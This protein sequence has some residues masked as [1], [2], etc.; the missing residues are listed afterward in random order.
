MPDLTC[1]QC[2]AVYYSGSGRTDRCPRCRQQPAVYQPPPQQQQ[3]QQLAGTSSRGRD[4]NCLRCGRAY[5]T[6]SGRTRLCMTCRQSE[7]SAPVAGSPKAAAGPSSRAPQPDSWPPF[8]PWASQPAQ[9]LP[10]AGP[11]SSA[12]DTLAAPSLKQPPPGG[13]AQ[14]PPPPSSLPPSQ[15]TR[16]GGR[17]RPPPLAVASGSPARGQSGASPAFPPAPSASESGASTPRLPGSYK[18]PAPPGVLASVR[19]A[20]RRA[21]QRVSI[22][23]GSPKGSSRPPRFASS[24]GGSCKSPTGA[25]RHGSPSAAARAPMQSYTKHPPGSGSPRAAAGSPGPAS[26][27]A[28][29]AAWG[30]AKRTHS[31]A[32]CG[33]SPKAASSPRR[34]TY[35]SAPCGGSPKASVRR[36][37]SFA[38]HKRPASVGGPAPSGA[39]RPPSLGAIPR[40]GSPGVS[41]YPR[42][43]SGSLNVSPVSGSPKSLPHRFPFGEPPPSGSPKAASSRRPSGGSPLAG[44]PK[45]A[46]PR[47]ASGTSPLGGSPKAA[48]RR[49]TFPQTGEQRSAVAPGPPQAS[50]KSASL[51][52][53]GPVQGSPKA[54][55]LRRERRATLEGPPARRSSREEHH[56]RPAEVRPRGD[57][58]FEVRWPEAVQRPLRQQLSPPRSRAPPLALH[59]KTEHSAPQHNQRRVPPA[60]HPGETASPIRR[61]PSPHPGG[62]GR[63]W[64]Q[65][66]NDTLREGYVDGWQL[67]GAAPPPPE[68][69]EDLAVLGRHYELHGWDVYLPD[70]SGA[71]PPAVSADPPAPCP[72]A[73]AAPTH[74]SPAS[75]RRGT[76]THWQQQHVQAH[77]SPP[78]G[79]TA[80]RS[81]STVWEPPLPAAAPPAARLHWAAAAAQPQPLGKSPARYARPTSPANAPLSPGAGLRR[82]ATPPAQSRYYPSS[83]SAARPG[84]N[85]QKQAASPSAPWPRPGPRATAVPYGSRAALSAC[86]QPHAA[87]WHSPAL[88]VAS[89]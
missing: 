32:P 55:S 13:P 41:S 65:S 36:P 58:S 49:P 44:S 20:S 42:P 24:S 68:G 29:G 45:P 16:S 66:H 62:P 39:G 67:H 18:Q 14:M 52:R 83:P 77:G 81:G 64:S 23:A 53:S 27:S 1:K 70:P 35:G 3:Q 80:S 2:G 87:P 85:T 11:P 78:Q 76:P 46:S 59:A 31:A 4:A 25:S 19:S 10:S 63:V 61:D 21:P 22:C 75:H 74:T 5:F 34:A 47:R 50:P 40:Y 30:G 48:S 28:R 51:R 38:A 6:A 79:R 7:P 84:W 33:G 8:D 37:P 82:A 17:P 9:P 60:L 73:P 89:Y 71:P 43:A 15:L 57:G 54:A 12:L 88:V 56:W 86:G 69:A 72:P 26:P